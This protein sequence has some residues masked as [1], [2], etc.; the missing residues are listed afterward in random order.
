M[1]ISAVSNMNSG[2]SAVKS[3]TAAMNSLFGISD[4]TMNLVNAAAA[5]MQIATGGAQLISVAV[6]AKET[7]NTIQTAKAATLTTAN[8]AIPGIGWG[9]I[10]LAVSAA[11]AAS[12]ITASIMNYTLSGDMSSSSG[13]ASILSKV[14]GIL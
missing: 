3:T 14:G 8:A 13:R 6:S 12:I 7:L 4:S 1:D 2:A 5:A 11:G 10:L 9:K